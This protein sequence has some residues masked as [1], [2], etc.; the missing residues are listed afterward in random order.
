[1]IRLHDFMVKEVYNP[2]IGTKVRVPSGI[3]TLTFES[4]TLFLQRPRLHHTISG[5]GR[6]ARVSF[7]DQP[8]VRAVLMCSI[9]A[10]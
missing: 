10:V 7:S 8:A 3:A 9:A 1:M 5:K 6:E 2:V 4:L